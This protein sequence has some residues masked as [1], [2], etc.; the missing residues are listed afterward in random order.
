MCS[1]RSLGLLRR[2]CSSQ[3][4]WHTVFAAQGPHNPKVLL[5][6]IFTYIEARAQYTF[7]FGTMCINDMYLCMQCQTMQ[8]RHTHHLVPTHMSH[9]LY[10]QRIYISTQESCILYVRIWMYVKLAH[11]GLFTVKTTHQLTAHPVQSPPPP[12][13]THSP[14]HTL[15]ALTSEFIGSSVTIPVVMSTSTRLLLGGV[16]KK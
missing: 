5:I 3:P 12:P 8:I 10:A 13:H 7:I 15:R 11:L 6:H 2:C 4:Q 16:T 1:Q 9:T 14:H